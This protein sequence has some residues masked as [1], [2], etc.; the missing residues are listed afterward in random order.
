M[1]ITLKLS[2]DVVRRLGSKVARE[3]ATE[4]VLGMTPEQA[5]MEIRP[6]HPET[7][8]LALSSFYT[9]DVADEIQAEQTLNR[10]RSSALV[11]AAYVKPADELP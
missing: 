4:T 7:D 10:L 2:E 5:N 11:E 6:L 8:D 9:V 3:R 1:Q